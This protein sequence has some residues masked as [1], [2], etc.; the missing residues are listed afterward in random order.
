VPHYVVYFFMSRILHAVTIFFLAVAVTADEPRQT[1]SDS[2]VP[3]MIDLDDLQPFGVASSREI[4]TLIR[5]LG[6]KQFKDRESAQNT[7]E[8]L[9]MIAVFRL[10]AACDIKDPE[11]RMRLRDIC[12]TIRANAKWRIRVLKSYMK[13]SLPNDNYS[14]NRKGEYH[15]EVKLFAGAGSDL[16]FL[17]GMPV[18]ELRVHKCTNEVDLAPLVGMPLQRLT[19]YCDKL[20]DISHLAGLPLRRVVLSGGHGEMPLRDI[21]SL[22]EQSL[23]HLD[24]GKTMVT[25]LTPLKSCNLSTIVFNSKRVTNGVEV[26]RDMPELQSINDTAAKTFWQ[27]YDESIR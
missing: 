9:G 3:D 16:S 21:R 25:D 23:Q 26:L 13:A 12:Q 10:E 14:I 6:A 5:Q 19:I 18:V 17:L 2:Q 20:T 11:V 7:L 24:I 22:A 15:C 27:T 8:S 4:T 1:R